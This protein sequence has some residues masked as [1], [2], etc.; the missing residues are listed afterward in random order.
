MPSQERKRPASASMLTPQPEPLATASAEHTPTPTKVVSEEFVYLSGRV[1]K[2]L[3]D[4][5]KRRAID[6]DRSVADLLADAV[7][8]YL[9][10]PAS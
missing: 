5:L 3:R 2:S 10:G 8:S 1:P 4:E 6:E 9:R 7:R